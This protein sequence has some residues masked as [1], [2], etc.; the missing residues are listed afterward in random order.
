MLFLNSS[1]FSIEAMANG[2]QYY[3]GPFEE[4]EVW[5]A[6]HIRTFVKTE[7]IEKGLVALNYNKINQSKYPTYEAYKKARSLEGLKALLIL[8]KEAWINER[9][10]EVEVTQGKGGIPGTQADKSI[11]NPDKFKKDIELVEKWIAE[12]QEPTKIEIE[13]VMPVIRKRGRPGLKVGSSN[14]QNQSASQV[15]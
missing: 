2:E 15:G 5:E 1:G 3:F 9:Q 11:I 14:D 13:E 7:Y 4:K 8:K 10:A 6:D 12:A